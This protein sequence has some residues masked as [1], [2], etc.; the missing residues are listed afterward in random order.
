MREV[1]YSK[2]RDYMVI[3][4]KG[5]TTSLSLRTNILYKKQKE[6]F[7]ITNKEFRKM[8]QNFSNSPYLGY[9]SEHVHSEPPEFYFFLIK[10]ISKLMESERCV[11][12]T[13]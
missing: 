3:P 12:T 9:T 13:S 6:I 11:D 2:Q 1:T 7:S 4:G 8:L 10:H 5:M